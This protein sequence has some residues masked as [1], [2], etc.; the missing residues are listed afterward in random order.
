MNRKGFIFFVAAG[1]D[2]PNP[3]TINFPGNMLEVITVGSY[4][5]LNE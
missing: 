5:I 1:N 2:G 3:M 4:N